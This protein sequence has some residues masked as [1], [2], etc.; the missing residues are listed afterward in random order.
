[1]LASKIAKKK[2]VFVSKFGLWDRFH[3]SGKE[4]RFSGLFWDQNV[5]LPSNTVVW[6]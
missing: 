3:S 1:M 2:L 4:S 6:M 5:I